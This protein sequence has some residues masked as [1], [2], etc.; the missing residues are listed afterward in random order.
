MLFTGSVR[1][2]ILFYFY[3]S[4]FYST[5]SPTMYILCCCFISFYQVR[6]QWF[7][8]VSCEIVDWNC[9]T[10]CTLELTPVVEYFFSS[11]LFEVCILKFNPFDMCCYSEIEYYCNVN[12]T[13]QIFSSATS[14]IKT[15]LNSILFL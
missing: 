6:F 2:F 7:R 9:L 10:V 12:M 11:R 4:K 5:Y 8:S 13:M 3:R 1:F 15:T 14:K